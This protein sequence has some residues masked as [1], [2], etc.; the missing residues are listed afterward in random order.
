[1]NSQF[2]KLRNVLI[3]DTLIR[4][5]LGSKKRTNEYAEQ[6]YGVGGDDLVP[7]RDIGLLQRHQVFHWLPYIEF[8]TAGG[9]SFGVSE[10]LA[11]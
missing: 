2:P 10:F 11:Q 7:M 9:G 1:M 3:R 6:E 8:G 5:L 4:N